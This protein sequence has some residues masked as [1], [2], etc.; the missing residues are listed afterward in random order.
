M[1][2]AEKRRN[3]P[4]D[5]NTMYSADGLQLLNMAET[6]WDDSGYDS[7]FKVT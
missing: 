4:Y 3:V 2:G 6:S 7:L 1:A 5:E